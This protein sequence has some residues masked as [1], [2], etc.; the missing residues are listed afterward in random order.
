M[1]KNQKFWD[2]NPKTFSYAK[3]GK[4]SESRSFT[5]CY[6]MCHSDAQI[7]MN[8]YNRIAE[9]S[10]VEIEM[11]KMNLQETVPAAV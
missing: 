6:V 9:K 4:Y 7:T 3:E 10:H 2:Y 11:S 1:Q 5:V 8:V